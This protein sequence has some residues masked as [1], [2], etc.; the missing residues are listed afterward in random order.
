MKTRTLIRVLAL[1]GSAAVVGFALDA[2]ASN[3]QGTTSIWN[4]VMSSPN[5]ACGDRALMLGRYEGQSNAQVATL[6][7]S[8][9]SSTIQGRDAYGNLLGSCQATDVAPVDGYSV[10]DSVGCSTGSSWT[11]KVYY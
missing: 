6:L 7:Y 10:G 8:G 4:S 5:G 9:W 11:W 3:C 1:L 2:E